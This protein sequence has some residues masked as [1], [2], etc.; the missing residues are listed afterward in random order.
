MLLTEVKVQKPIVIESVEQGDTKRPQKIKLN[1]IECDIQGANKRVYPLKEMENQVSMLD[2]KINSRQLLGELDHPSGDERSSFIYAKEQSHIITNIK[3]NNRGV[4]EGEFEILRETPNGK[5]LVNL[6]NQ[7]VSIGTSL[8]QSG[9]LRQGNGNH[10]VES[11]EIITW[12]IVQNPSYQTTYFTKQ[13]LI[14]NI[15][16]FKEKH[17]DI[18]ESSMYSKKIKQ[19]LNELILFKLL[20]QQSNK[21]K[22]RL[23][24]TEI[25]TLQKIIDDELNSYM[26]KPGL[27]KKGGVFNG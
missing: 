10:I 17:Q 5:I 26:N 8:R 20:E 3:I 27:G 13:N 21:N 15:S 1:L 23:K 14:E 16:Y 9:E 18:F 6:I 11:L 19:K 12:D 22:K 2:D 7:D 24:E 25:K 4:V